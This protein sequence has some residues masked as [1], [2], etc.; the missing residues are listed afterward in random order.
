MAMQL[1]VVVWD[2]LFYR[3]LVVEGETGYLVTPN[4]FSGMTDKVLGLLSSPNISTEMGAHGR[5]LLESK[6]NWSKLAGDVLGVF[7][8]AAKN[9]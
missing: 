6:Y 3:G 7:T 2:F 1:P 9:E 4:D 8:L 5:V